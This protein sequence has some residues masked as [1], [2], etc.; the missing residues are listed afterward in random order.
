MAHIYEA[1]NKDE[2]EALKNYQKSAELGN[3]IAKNILALKGKTFIP[4]INRNLINPASN[5][6]KILNNN[7]S[8]LVLEENTQNSFNLNQTKQNFNK[9]KYAPLPLISSYVSSGIPKQLI[10]KQMDY[11]SQNFVDLS[12]KSKGGRL[13]PDDHKRHITPK[14]SER[15]QENR[16]FSKENNNRIFTKFQS[17]EFKLLA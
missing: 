8:Q 4:S 9:P 1:V 11:D 13:N 2:E 14:N 16:G 5:M 15:K 3:E 7:N 17:D 12:A 10:H 6:S